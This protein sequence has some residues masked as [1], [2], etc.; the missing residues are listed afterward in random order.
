MLTPLRCQA[1]CLIVTWARRPPFFVANRGYGKRDAT[2][3][4]TLP[5]TVARTKVHVKPT[6]SA[7]TPSSDR[8]ARERSATPKL[9]NFFPSD[10]SL[11][12]LF[13]IDGFKRY[14]LKVV[15]AQESSSRSMKQFLP[16]KVVSARH[17]RIS[18]YL[19]KR[20]TY[21]WFFLHR[22]VAPAQKSRSCS[23]FLVSKVI[24]VRHSQMS[25]LWCQFPSS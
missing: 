15:P 20:P 10:E 8:L 5:S 25:V 13:K 12:L 4:N 16:S 24:P 9:P 22:K 21:L 1:Q 2:R 11:R 3:A 6:H 17:T 23:Y 7:F 19:C 14:I 18:E